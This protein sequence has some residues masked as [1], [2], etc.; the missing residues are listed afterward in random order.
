MPTAYTLSFRMQ[1]ENRGPRN[2]YAR[3]LA[4]A[5]ASYLHLP[6]PIGTR[7]IFDL[8][9]REECGVVRRSGGYNKNEDVNNDNRS[10]FLA[11]SSNLRPAKPR[12]GKR[13]RQAGATGGTA[14]T[15]AG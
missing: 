9:A 14:Q 12:Q 10:G 3:T 7:I 15:R 11:E 1:Q 13:Q 8:P 2:S 6:L 4:V 5:R